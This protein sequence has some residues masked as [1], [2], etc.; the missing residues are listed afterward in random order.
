MQGECMKLNQWWLLSRGFCFGPL[1]DGRP[2]RN[3]KKDI[4]PTG[5]PTSSDSRDRATPWLTEGQEAQT[6]Q[7]KPEGI[8]TA[9]PKALAPTSAGR[10][11]VLLGAFS[12]A[13]VSA[14]TVLAAGLVRWTGA[15]I[16]PSMGDGRSREKN[17]DRPPPDAGESAGSGQ[18]PLVA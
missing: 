8:L 7:S 5:P 14:A 10:W 3:P 16:L 6:F 12:P 18:P 15:S 2:V 4:S 9:G 11:G 1:P 17:V 13:A